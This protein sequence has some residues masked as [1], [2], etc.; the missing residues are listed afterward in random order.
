ME[1][2]DFLRIVSDF[3]YEA[4]VDI[5]NEVS[6]KLFKTLVVSQDDD[7]LYRG[8]NAESICE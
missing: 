3:L 7:N 5:L 8:L 4:H 1:I 2:R 6:T